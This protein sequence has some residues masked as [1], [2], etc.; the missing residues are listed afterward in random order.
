[1]TYNVQGSKRQQRT[2]VFNFQYS[3]KNSS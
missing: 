2:R 1:M 3:D